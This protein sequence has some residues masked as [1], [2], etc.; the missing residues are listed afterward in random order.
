MEKELRHEGDYF[1]EGSD[2]FKAKNGE[3]K[4]FQLTWKAHKIF[5]YD[6]ELKGVERTFDMTQL[7]P[8]GWAMTRDSNNST[9]AYIDTGDEYIYKADSSKDFELVDKIKV[10][11]KNGNG[12]KEINEIEFVNGKL[13]VNQWMTNFIMKV[14]PDTGKVEANIDFGILMYR[15]QWFHYN[16]NGLGFGLNDVMNGI[17]FD[18]DRGTFYVTGKNWKLVYEVEIVK[19]AKY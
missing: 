12:V 11:D 4:I 17:A 13:W 6:L 3:H 14:D 7:I 16:E 10:T 5:Q 2:I 15:A 9:L 1:G 8:K 19:E 18:R